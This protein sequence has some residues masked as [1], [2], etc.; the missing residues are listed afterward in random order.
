ME[1]AAREGQA[2]GLALT[3]AQAVVGPAAGSTPVGK[4]AGEQAGAASVRQ[5]KS[6]QGPPRPVGPA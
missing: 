6:L 2:S 1:F 3:T 5:T 4:Q